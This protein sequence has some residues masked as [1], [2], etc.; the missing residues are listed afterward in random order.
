MPGTL[1][2]LI[3]VEYSLL[4]GSCCKRFRRITSFHLDSS[5]GRVIGSISQVGK[6]RHRMTNQSESI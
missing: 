6:L 5:T 1:E 3:L 2:L 4:D